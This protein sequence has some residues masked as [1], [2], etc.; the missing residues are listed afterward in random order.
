MHTFEV[1]HTV[2]IIGR[3]MEEDNCTGQGTDKSQIVMHGTLREDTAT[4][5]LIRGTL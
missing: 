2:V 5:W 3:S 4:V 1:K